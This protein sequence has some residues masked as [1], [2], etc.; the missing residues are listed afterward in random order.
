MIYFVLSTLHMEF[1]IGGNE[2]GYHGTL[3]VFKSISE[4]PFLSYPT[5][6]ELLWFLYSIK[7]Y[8]QLMYMIWTWQLNG[9][10]FRISALVLAFLE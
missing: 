9:Y 3:S 10:C 2:G 7:T 1:C 4:L 8:V 5:I 6:F